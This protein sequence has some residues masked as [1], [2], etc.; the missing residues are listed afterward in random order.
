M[1][2]YLCSF[3]FDKRQKLNFF[4]MCKRR[5]FA[6]EMYVIKSLILILYKPFIL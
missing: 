4:I 2:L 3:L 5:I 6:K 1:L